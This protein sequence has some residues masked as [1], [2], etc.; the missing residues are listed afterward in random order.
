MSRQELV[1]GLFKETFQADPQA[2]IHAPGRVNLIGEHTDYNGGFVLPAA[3]NFGTDI[4]CSLRE[5]REVHILAADLEKEVIS[6]SLDDIK[7]DEAHS[8][9]NYVRGVLLSLMKVYPNIKGATLVVSGNVPQGAGLSSSASF[10]IA[11]LKAFSQLNDLDLDGIKAA[12]M[13]QEAENEFVG[14]SCGIMDQLISAMGKKDQA[15]LLDCE[16]LEIQYTNVPTSLDLVIINSNVKRGLVDSEYNTRRQQCENA[17]KIM[18]VD[19]LRG[20]DLA[21]LAEFK[22]QLSELEYKRAHHVITE[23]QRTL[24]MLDALNA[25][26]FAKVSELMK[27]SHASMRDDFEITTSQI[28][29]LVEIVDQVIGSQGGVRMTGG[30]FGGCVVALVPKALTDAVKATIN[31]NYFNKTGLQADIFICSA[32]QGAFA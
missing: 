28:D 20:A 17:A 32:E 5:D 31:E 24:D 1:T 15:M 23:N 18:Q 6:F 27:G 9:S 26:E 8:W 10:E 29:Y 30:G 7:H 16:S 22:P 4:A 3:I 11:I 14:C 13:G 2:V 21:K 19:T 25:G 12:L